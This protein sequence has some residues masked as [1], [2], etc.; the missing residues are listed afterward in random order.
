M[1]SKIKILMI[2]D[3]VR[4]SKT[5]AL[6]LTR[7]GR[8]SVDVENNPLEACATALRIQP[9]LIILDVI[10]PF[11][12][13]G[14]VASE[15]RQE[16]SLSAVPVIFMTSIMDHQEAAAR[17]NTLGNDPVLAKPVTMPELIAQIDALLS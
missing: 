11:K 14:T 13:G 15:I 17:G 9:D 5:V 7:T 8:F 12:D 16:P 1:A 10:M 3:D 4:L 6:L 2:D